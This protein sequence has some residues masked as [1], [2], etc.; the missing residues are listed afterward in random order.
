MLARELQARAILLEK[1]MTSAKTAMT[2]IGIPVDQQNIIQA[3]ISTSDDSIYFQNQLNRFLNQLTPTLQ[4][5]ITKNLFSI[6]CTESK[7]V[8]QPVTKD[9]ILLRELQFVGAISQPLLKLPEDLVISQ[10]SST[11]A[12]YFLSKGQLRVS[13]TDFAGRKNDICKIK[14]GGIFGEIS[15]LLK[16]QRT[17]TIR[18]IDYCVCLYLPRIKGING[19]LK[20]LEA[21]LTDQFMKY[22]DKGHQ[23]TR[24]ILT[25]GIDFLQEKAPHLA[26][27]NELLKQIAY[28]MVYMQFAK[29]DVIVKEDEP[30]R[31]I[32]IIRSGIV[33]LNMRSSLFES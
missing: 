32:Y 1:K 15:Y 26:V 21:L 16:C 29:N 7:L 17:A 25:Q 6:L 14:P 11:T 8:S 5:G 10:G 3:F 23:V 24:F 28:N 18:C 27:T 33:S 9:P 2:S 20:H 30:L 12:L 31:G 4:A 22:Q 19:S 13:C